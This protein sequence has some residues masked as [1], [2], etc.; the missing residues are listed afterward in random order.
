[1]GGRVHFLDE[2]VLDP[3]KRIGRWRDRK[4]ALFL[5][6]NMDLFVLPKPTGGVKLQRGATA[7]EGFRDTNDRIIR[8]GIGSA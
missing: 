2:K 4:P 3:A 7:N 1:M 5:F 8:L 6:N